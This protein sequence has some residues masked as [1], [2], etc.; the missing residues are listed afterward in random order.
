MPCTAKPEQKS[1]CLCTVS[2]I[3]AGSPLSYTARKVRKVCSLL[4]SIVW[5]PE[6]WLQ[7]QQKGTIGATG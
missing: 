5:S 6:N 2:G 4:E 3:L 1:S 7:L